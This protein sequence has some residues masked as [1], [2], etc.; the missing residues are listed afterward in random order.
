MDKHKQL[1]YGLGGL[2]VLL[3]GLGV[4]LLSER[5][6]EVVRSIGHHLDKAPKTIEQFAD[7]TQVELDRIQQTLNQIAARLQVAG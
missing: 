4:F 6:R 7:A 5:G 1:T 2:G 3:G